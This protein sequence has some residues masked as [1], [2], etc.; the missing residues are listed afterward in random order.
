MPRLKVLKNEELPVEFRSQ[1]EQ[2]ESAGEDTTHLR[3][4]GHRADMFQVYLPWYFEANEGG[5]LSPKLKE[6][7]RLFI[8]KL[9][10]CST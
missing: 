8:A 6:T 5:V 2:M 10:D 7:V 1:V 4:L 9:N 3:V